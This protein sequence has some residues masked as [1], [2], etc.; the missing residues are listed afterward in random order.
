MMATTTATRRT[1]W[2]M[3]VWT[4]RNCVQSERKNSP[5]RG[6][7]IIAVVTPHRSE[8]CDGGRRRRRAHV[9]KWALAAVHE[10]LY[11]RPRAAAVPPHAVLPRSGHHGRGARRRGRRERGVELLEERREIRNL[12][13]ALVQLLVGELVQPNVPPVELVEG[14]AAILIMSPGAVLIKS[15]RSSRCFSSI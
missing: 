15:F 4:K 11:T 2:M 9:S 7:H 13:D 10:A 12:S 6:T 5:S 3:N 14:G 8:G 1:C